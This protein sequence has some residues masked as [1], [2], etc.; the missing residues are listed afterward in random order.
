MLPLQPPISE[1]R[2]QERREYLDAHGLPD[3]WQ[4]DPEDLQP[5]WLCD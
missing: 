3:E 2:E 1:D 4:P 5:W